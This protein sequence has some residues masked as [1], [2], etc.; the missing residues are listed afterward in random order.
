[1]REEIEIFAGA[2]LENSGCCTAVFVDNPLNEGEM[3]IL[4]IG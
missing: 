1:M 2:S 4:E 3:E